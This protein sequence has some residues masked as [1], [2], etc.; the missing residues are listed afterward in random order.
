MPL[1]IWP[2]TN[3]HT[4]NL[5]WI[6]KKI[7]NVETAESNTAA[8]EEAA[9][10]SAASAAASQEA[11][12]ES[13][14]NAAASET[15]A[16]NYYNNIRDNVSTLVTGWMDEH[17]TPTT[18][19]VDDTLTI[20]GAA[21]DAKKTGDEITDLKNALNPIVQTFS[22]ERPNS[23][24]RTLEIN[25]SVGDVFRVTNNTDS[26]LVIRFRDTE[27]GENKQVSGV[28][29]NSTD[30]IVATV[31]ASWIQVYFQSAGSAI[32]EKG[33]I[34]DIEKQVDTNAELLGN[35]VASKTVTRTVV[36]GSTYDQSVS[37][38]DVF[39]VTNNTNENIA[40]RLADENLNFLQANRVFPG[41]TAY[42][43]AT[44]DATKINLYF[45]AAGSV[46]VETGRV[47]DLEGDTEKID[48][49]FDLLVLEQGGITQIGEYKPLA[50]RLRTV[51]YLK[52]DFKVTAPNG[53]VVFGAFFFDNL[54]Y[55]LSSQININSQTVKLSVEDG[56]FC[57]LVFTKS[58]NT[59]SITVEE[60][61]SSYVL[62]DFSE[63]IS[64][65]E[66]PP[67]V[68]FTYDHDFYTNVESIVN[69][70]QYTTS[71]QSMTQLYGW[72]D[73]LVTADP[74]YVTKTD[75]AQELGLTYPRYANGISAGDAE[76]LETPAY[77]TYI[78]KFACENSGV[79]TALQ[80]KKK[81]IILGGVHGDEQASPF[82][83]YMFAYRL[84]NDY[85]TD[86][87]MYNLRASADFYIVPCV[88]GYGMI[89][90]WRL[91]GNGVNINRNFPI[92]KWSKY[93]EKGQDNY[94]GETAGSEF[95]TQLV[96][97]LVDSVKPDMFIDHHNYTYNLNCQFYTDIF[98]IKQ[99]NLS[100]QALSDISYTLKK[101]L[102]SYF[103]TNFDFV[104]N[105]G[106]SPGSTG[107]TYGGT[108]RWAYEEQVPFSATVEIGD[109]I[110]Y[111]NG[112]HAGTRQ[113]YYGVDTFK[114]AEYTLRNQILHYLQWVLN[115]A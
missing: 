58:D 36:G 73:E 89:H 8:S 95:E 78:Y 104:K 68:E 7:K 39:R 82:N 67:M 12:A 94:T 20:Q 23:G 50:N 46:V 15:A 99:L 31:T 25:V 114:V 18:P 21:A 13:E 24:G 83:L 1:F 11:A 63:R 49:V 32:I 28:S 9:A 80:K 59:Q 41:E 69:E 53:F 102:P 96:M 56:Q 62:E 48:N 2:Y 115:N 27:T 19:P 47:V 79:N 26:N 88:N 81:V 86:E 65:L 101:N 112:V 70:K 75:V 103:G 72:F 110:T 113:N 14:E 51:N 17:I 40:F 87:N 30:Y 33:Q 100:Y 35:L 93:G 71:P 42:I 85:L 16:A 108:S 37:V 91:N 98:N 34:V 64:T 60:I 92:V 74:S 97:A 38:G 61:K 29:P 76:Y 44:V 105:N 111:L 52:G 4:L 106:G 54:G 22:F 107:E 10:G 5:D 84:V 109:C 55:I 45:N 66:N 77:K 57:K 90:Q 43:T 3:L 6:I